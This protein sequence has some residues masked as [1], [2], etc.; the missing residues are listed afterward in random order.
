M[1]TGDQEIVERREIDGSRLLRPLPRGSR[2]GGTNRL[3]P[4]VL[5]QS[6]PLADGASLNLRAITPADRVALR[7]E[8]FLKLGPDSLRNRFFGT[9]L[10]LS[11]VELARLCQVDFLRHVAIVAETSR[12]GRRRLVGV[13]RFVRAE[14]DAATAEVAI[15]VQDHYQGRG[16]GGQLLC[17]LVVAARELGLSRLEGSMFAQNQR[18]ARLMRA[19]QLPC[20]S[21]LEDGILTISLD[22]DGL[23]PAGPDRSVA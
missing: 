6:R 12:A 7:E 1:K 23:P 16:I 21:S 22:L 8:L 10:D 4:S 3:D 11:E 19:L 5:T 20:E 2:A 9:K 14:D 17:R 15:T 18:M 13:G